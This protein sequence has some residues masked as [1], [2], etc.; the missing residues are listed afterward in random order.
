MTDEPTPGN[1]TPDNENKGQEMN[2]KRF[3]WRVANSALDAWGAN[4]KA[5]TAY[6]LGTVFAVWLMRVVLSNYQA[7]EEVSRTTAT[8]NAE[9]IHSISESMGTMAL[10][11]TKRMVLVEATHAMSKTAM[12]EARVDRTERREWQS[13]LLAIQEGVKKAVEDNGEK[14]DSGNKIGKT[15]RAEQI[16]ILKGIFDE[17]KKRCEQEEKHAGKVDGVEKKV[18]ECLKRLPTPTPAKL[19]K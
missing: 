11:D 12:E 2:G 18:D 5:I 10:N 14:I 1:T 7:N 17:S 19:G 9:S 4:W 16:T 8:Q 6:G 3:G 13:K 15:E